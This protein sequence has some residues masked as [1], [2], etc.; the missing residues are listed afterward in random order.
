M[1]TQNI[2]ESSVG[3]DI[4]KPGFFVRARKAALNGGLTAL[5]IVGISA[6]G[7]SV[8]IASITPSNAKSLAF[9]QTNTPIP[10]PTATITPSPTATP[11]NYFSL[12]SPFS[13]ECGSPGVWSNDSYNGKVPSDYGSQMDENH[14]HVDIMLPSGCN[15]IIVFSPANGTLTK[16]GV[17][18]YDLVLS[19]GYALSL[20]PDNPPGFQIA[21]ENVASSSNNNTIVLK[22][23]HFQ[24]ITEGEVTKG[25]EIGKLVMEHNHWK[26]AYQVTTTR[27]GYRIWSPTLF[28]QDIPMTC[29]I[30]SP[31]D[32]VPELNDFKS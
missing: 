11:I 32:C 4:G 10:G 15:S 22:L 6:C 27:G 30:D 3:S 25:Q 26:L 1:K 14:G 8:T 29:V 12:G 16:V 17:N 5:A 18:N 19:Q 2:P 23:A 9:T 13:E 28:L 20:N 31:Y 24:S 21:L 7:S